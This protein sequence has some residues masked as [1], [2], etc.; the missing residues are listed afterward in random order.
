MRVSPTKPVAIESHGPP[1]DVA[2]AD[3]WQRLATD[4]RPS[5]PVDFPRKPPPGAAPYPQVHVRVLRQAE[6]MTCMAAADGYAREMLAN[7]KGTVDGLGYHDLYTDAKVCE[8]LWHACRR[9][10]GAPVFVSSKG[11]RQ[12]L[13]GDEIAVLFQSYTE[14]QNES[15]PVIATMTEPELDAWIDRLKEGAARLFLAQLSSEAR[16]DLLMRSI[17]RLQKSET[18]SSSRGSQPSESLESPPPADADGEVPAPS[19]AD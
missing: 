10:D 4:P 14:W 17:A 11:L 5:T 7:Q 13:N 15:G 1:E 9:E 3:L 6:I 19:E 12:L 2:P 18:G 8:L 16:T